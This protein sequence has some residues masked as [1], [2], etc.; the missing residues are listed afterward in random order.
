VWVKKTFEEIYYF[1]VLS[2]NRRIV[3]KDLRQENEYLR[4]K[5]EGF[6]FIRVKAEE[7]LRI[8]R[9][10]QSDDFDTDDL[11][12]KTES[13]IDHFAVDYEITNN[14]SLDEL[15]EQVTTIITRIKEEE[16]KQHLMNNRSK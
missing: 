1:R 16:V 4:C 7:E 12:D 15:Y 11:T 6:I 3:I 8:E 9:C 14:G 13:H 10:K 5:K 2:G